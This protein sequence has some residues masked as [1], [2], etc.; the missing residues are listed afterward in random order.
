MIAVT[1]RMW[2]MCDLFFCMPRSMS[3]AL[4]FPF[5]FHLHARFF[6]SFFS[7]RTYVSCATFRLR[8]LAWLQS[9]IK[10]VPLLAVYFGISIRMLLTSENEYFIYEIGL[11]TNP[12]VGDMEADENGSKFSRRRS[13]FERSIQ[14]NKLPKLITT[15]SCAAFAVS[16]SAGICELRSIAAIFQSQSTR[17]NETP[18]FIYYNTIVAFSNRTARAF[19]T[20]DWSPVSSARYRPIVWQCRCA[21]MPG[22]FHLFTFCC[23]HISSVDC[24]PAKRTKRNWCTNAHIAHGT[25]SERVSS[26]FVCCCGPQITEKLI[27]SFSVSLIALVGAIRKRKLLLNDRP[28]IPRLQCISFSSHVYLFHW[29]NW[30]PAL[31]NEF[32]FIYLSMHMNVRMAWAIVKI[33]DRSRS[34]KWF[35]NDVCLPEFFA[36]GDVKKERNIV[37]MTTG[38]LLLLRSSSCDNSS[39]VLGVND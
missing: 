2:T 15:A 3:A 4:A 1:A 14:R 10:C 27:V 22:P 23:M 38:P 36:N 30:L 8:Q 19:K 7:S 32:I 11:R 31:D 25:N 24:R 29:E 6:G 39:L 34:Q 18:A 20:L 13:R 26:T 9:A 28:A 21:G 16:H 37:T 12:I 35:C 17:Q 5:S 33:M